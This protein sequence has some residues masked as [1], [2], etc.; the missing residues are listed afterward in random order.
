MPPKT[1][2]VWKHFLCD[3]GDSKSARCRHCN[4]KIKYLGNTTNLMNHL[5][6]KHD[7]KIKVSS[8][9]ERRISL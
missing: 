3:D 5:K 4:A 8:E 1:S 9:S 6:R 2:I 7:T